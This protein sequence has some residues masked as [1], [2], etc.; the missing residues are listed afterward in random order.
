MMNM[1]LYNP[2]SQRHTHHSYVSIYSCTCT[3][4]T[5]MY[6]CHL[7]GDNSRIYMWNNILYYLIHLS[8]RQHNSKSQCILHM[9]L[10]RHSHSSRSGR[11]EHTSLIT[12]I[13]CWRNLNIWCSFRRICRRRINRMRRIIC[14]IAM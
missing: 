5:I 10:Q 11:M 7:F 14:R 1:D 13:C 6:M 3:G 2:H 4:H 12:D 8:N 9:H